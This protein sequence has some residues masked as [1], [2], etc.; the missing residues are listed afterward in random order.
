MRRPPPRGKLLAK[1]RPVVVNVPVAVSFTV[2]GAVGMR[3]WASRGSQ[4]PQNCA[5]DVVA[6]SERKIRDTTTLALDYPNRMV[7][8]SVDWLS[9]FE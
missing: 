7:N 5:V 8:S 3:L 9:H 1:F 6:D 4:Q 2:V